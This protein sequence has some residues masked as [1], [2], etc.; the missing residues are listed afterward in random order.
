MKWSYYIEDSARVP[1]SK[2]AIFENPLSLDR[3]LDNEMNLL[4]KDF[5]DIIEVSN[6][7]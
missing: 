2:R 1:L 4:D 6:L 3:R 5:K 7:N